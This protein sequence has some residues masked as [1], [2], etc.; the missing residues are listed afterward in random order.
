[1]YLRTTNLAY[2]GGD[3][4]NAHARELQEQAGLAPARSSAF[5]ALLNRARSSAAARKKN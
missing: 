2:H 1:M 4:A 3:A 5:D